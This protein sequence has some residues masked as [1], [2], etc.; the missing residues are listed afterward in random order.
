MFR[1]DIFVAGFVT[2]YL[3]VY[4]AL[5]QST[6]TRDYA[7][8]MLLFSPLLLCWMVFTVLKYG[9]Y[10]GKE[11]GDDEEFGYQDKPKD[12]LGVF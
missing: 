2:V 6:H 4:I 11:L 1:N 3:V 9:R 7:F 10:T 5:L 12:E 8:L